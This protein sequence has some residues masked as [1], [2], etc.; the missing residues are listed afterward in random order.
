MF[1]GN[2]IDIF[3]FSFEDISVLSNTRIDLF[4]HNNTVML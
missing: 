2:V 4:D 1:V 3:V